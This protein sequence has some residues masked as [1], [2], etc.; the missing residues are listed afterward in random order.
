MAHAKGITVEGEIGCLGGIEDGHGT[1][2][3]GLSHLTDPDQAV[4]FVQAHRPRRSAIAI[5]TSHGAYKFSSKPPA[6]RS[7]WGGSSRSTTSCPTF[8]W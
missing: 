5:G 6:R 7:R 8:T 3:D 4:E 1:G 2:L